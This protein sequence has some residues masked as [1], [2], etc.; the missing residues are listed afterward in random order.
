MILTGFDFYL[1]I[2]K[3]RNSHYLS[4]MYSDIYIM[5]RDH[6]PSGTVKAH[7]VRGMSAVTPISNCGIGLTL[8]IMYKGFY[9]LIYLNRKAYLSQHYIF[10]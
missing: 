3:H 9:I 2:S 5:Y 7:N 1:R 4:W 10:S 6:V 8:C